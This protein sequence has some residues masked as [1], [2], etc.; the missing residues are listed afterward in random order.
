MEDCEALRRAYYIEKK[1]IRQ[2]AREQHHSSRTIAKVIKEAAPQPYRQP[3]TRP[4]P[5][6]VHTHASFSGMIR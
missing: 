4:A 1:S 2:I 5:V 6:L 3:I